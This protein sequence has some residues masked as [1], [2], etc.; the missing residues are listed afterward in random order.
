MYTE[1]NLPRLSESILISTSADGGP[2]SHVRARGTLRS[3][4]YRPYR[5][6]SST[7]VCRVGFLQISHFPVKIGLIGGVGGIPQ[8]SFSL[9][10]Q[11]FCYLGAD[12]K[13]QNCSTNPSGRNSPFRHLSAQNRLFKGARGGPQIFFPLEYY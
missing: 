1:N 6:F 8:I 11:S 7:H 12:G 5:K 13:F 4:P 3:A 9:D 10:S 2:P